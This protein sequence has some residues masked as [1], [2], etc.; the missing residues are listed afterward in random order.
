[1]W[2]WEE[3]GASAFPRLRHWLLAAV[4]VLGAM[5]AVPIFAALT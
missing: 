2:P 4:L 1:M 5:L 3:E